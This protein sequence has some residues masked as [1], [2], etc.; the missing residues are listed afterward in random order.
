MMPGTP[1]Q[2]S[3]A[4]IRLVSLQSWLNGTAT[5]VTT[6]GGVGSMTSSVMTVDAVRLCASRTVTGIDFTPVVDE[7]GTMAEYEKTLSAATASGA[8]PSSNNVVDAAPPIADRSAVTVSAVLDGLVPG[9]TF[10][11]SSV[12]A[13][14]CTIAGLAAPVAEGLVV[15]DAPVTLMSSMPTHS[16]L[17]AALVVMM[18]SCTSGWSSVDAGSVTETGVTRVAAPGSVASG[19]YAA[20]TFVKSPVEPTR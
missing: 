11:V 13:P 18:R 7:V 17:P 3:L 4:V 1:A 8:T 20:G 15:P 19:T 14:F 2:L 10:T 5:I 9:V 16:S 6:G 12:L